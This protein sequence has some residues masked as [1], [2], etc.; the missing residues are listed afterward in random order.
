MYMGAFDSNDC[1]YSATS[2]VF[3][4]EWGGIVIRQKAKSLKTNTS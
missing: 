3:K 1:G 2:V 4:V